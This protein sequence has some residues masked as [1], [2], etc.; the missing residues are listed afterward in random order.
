MHRTIRRV[1]VII[2]L[3]LAGL[4]QAQATDAHV[5]VANNGNLE[6]SVSS[7]RLNADGTLSFV[8]R[9]VTGTRP[10]TST[11]CPGCN[12]YAIS[13]SPNGRF[14]A[15]NHA[16][17]N[18]DENIHVYEVAPDGTLSLARSITLPEGG[19]DIEWVR[20]DLLAVCITS[21]SG[22]NELRLYSW[23]AQ[24]KT[25]S[26]AS[27]APG[28]SFLTNIAVHPNGEWIFGNDSFSFIVRRYRVNG[29]TIT[30]QASTPI[31]VYGVALGISPD[32]RFLYAAGGISAGGRAFSGHAIDPVTG[33]L[34]DLPGSPFTSPG[35]SPKGFTFTPDGDFMYVSHGTDAT[36][37][38]FRIDPESGVPSVQPSMFDVGLQG[39]L[40][41]MDTLEGRL[42]ALD[43]S[44][45]IDGLVGAY[46]FAVDPG[47]GAITLSPNA[48][49]ATQGI[50][51]NDIAAWPGASCPADLT[52]DG[53]L[54]FFDLA[55]YLDRYNSQDPTAD[56]AAPFGV[57]NFFDL[58]AYLDLY[59]TGCP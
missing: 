2:V 45:A 22:T 39:T 31:P 34:S 49:F 17:G 43:N 38:T 56:L 25:L 24:T 55:T 33:A 12:T 23:N 30:L 29:N 32:G 36:I 10:N 13:L 1:T 7:M 19:L 14:L 46:S 8:D 51:P 40:Q 53:T 3:S 21:L 6:G 16:S 11:P 57:L 37:R 27:S 18:F 58:A 42:F 50:S 4:A 20:D 47:S 59:N 54:N 26:L 28:G 5:F 52:G 35:A 48:P 15:T 44:S 41:G 9:V